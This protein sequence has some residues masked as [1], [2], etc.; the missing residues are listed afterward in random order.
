MIIII[1]VVVIRL[2]ILL[3]KHG[4]QIEYVKT[5]LVCVTAEVFI[6]RHVQQK[7]N[8]ETQNLQNI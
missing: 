8:A 3:S 6:H 7:Q 5:Q 4:V 2:M 1:F